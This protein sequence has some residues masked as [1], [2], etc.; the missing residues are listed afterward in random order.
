MSAGTYSLGES[1]APSGEDVLDLESMLGGV[2]DISPSLISENGL[3]SALNAA[4]PDMS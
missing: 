1:F 4:L 3:V 2:S